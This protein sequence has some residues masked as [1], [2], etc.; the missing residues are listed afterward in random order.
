MAVVLYEKKERIAYITLNR[1]EKLNAINQEMIEE[2]QKI[3]VD[4][5]EDHDLW[6]AILGANG[7]AFSAGADVAGSYPSATPVR[8]GPPP[9]DLRGFSKALQGSPASFEVWKPIIAALHGYV[10]GAALWISLCC[11]LR[12]AAEDTQ[13]GMPEVKYGRA[14]TIAGLFSDYVPLGIAIELMLLGDPISAERAYQLGI[15]NKVVPREELMM[16]AIRL[17]EKI[18][19]NSPLALR[20]TKEVI[21]RSKD[22]PSIEAK[23][24]LAEARFASVRELEDSKEAIKAFKEKGNLCGNA[25]RYLVCQRWGDLP[26]SASAIPQTN[27]TELTVSG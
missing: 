26:G 5:R 8:P 1:P 11:D 18:C 7:K 19:E 22:I 3:W 9:K 4:F 14:V 2:L 21:W 24:G 10:Y 12:I 23:L 6:V 15:V 20:A 13:I 17:A 25:N 16:T 27:L